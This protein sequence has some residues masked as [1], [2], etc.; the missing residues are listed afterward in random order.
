MNPILAQAQTLDSI[1]AGFWKFFCIGILVL[2]GVAGSI[3]FIIISFRKPAPTKIDDEP[4]V[5]VRKVSPR[6]NHEAIDQR[7]GRIESRLDG[8]DSEID[9]AWLEMKRMSEEGNKTNL[10]IQV[11]LARIE[12]HLGIIST[13]EKDTKQ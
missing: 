6:Y 8:H 7:F 12:V 10:G 13:K 2:L 3:I 9:A 4:A 1:P 5:K 11:S